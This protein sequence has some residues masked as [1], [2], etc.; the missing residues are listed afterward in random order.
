MSSG[1]WCKAIWLK[2]RRTPLGQ[3]CSVSRLRAVFLRQLEQERYIDIFCHSHSVV[4]NC[5]V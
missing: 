5:K 4:L 2:I 3:S 1:W